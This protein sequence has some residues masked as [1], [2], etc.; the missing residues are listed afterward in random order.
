M[1]R[2]YV[3]SSNLKS[4]GYDPSTSTLEIEFHSNAIWQYFEVS[5]YVYNEFRSAESLGKY[6]NSCIRGQFAESRVG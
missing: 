6:F 1:E 3:E 5:E 4:I 2:V